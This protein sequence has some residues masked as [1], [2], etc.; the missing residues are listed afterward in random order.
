MTAFHAV[1]S[2]LYEGASGISLFLARLA[3]ITGDRIVRSTAEAAQAQ[4]LTL[5]D[6]LVADGEYGFYSGLSGIAWACREAGILLAVEELA[7]HGKAALQ[8]A[9]RLTPD[10]RRVDVMNGSAGLIPV[11]LDAA[12]ANQS[13]E[14]FA[15][16]VRHGEHLLNLAERSE[17]GWSWDTL[18]SV[19]EPHL[20]GFAHGASGIAYALGRLASAT[21][22][23]DFLAGV[24]GALRYERSLFRLEEGN[25]PDLRSFAQPSKGGKPPCMIAWCH[26]AAGIGIARLALH[27]VLPNE[28][29][30]LGDAEIAIRT[31]APTLERS[32][33]QETGNFSLCH[34]D[35]G[36]ADLLILADDL[37]ERPELRQH[38]EAAGTH[39]LEQF[40]DLCS[41]WP[42]GVQGAGETPSLFLGLAGIG[43]FFL[44]LYD[45]KAVPT[46]LLPAYRGNF[47]W[48]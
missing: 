36:N 3:N 46:V 39:A 29:A 19:D 15:A 7:E 2:S 22:R 4:A 10:R 44:R 23:S 5:V 28:P 14:M 25:W 48:L 18:G 8:L 47:Q 33:T 32:L 34:G 31:T 20:L 43:S 24:R 17:Q 45:S 35:A 16:A 38:A 27:K 26:G 30:I 9:A 40:E 6:A 12:A 1:G 21:N 41:P 37:L 13:D 11:L 42:C